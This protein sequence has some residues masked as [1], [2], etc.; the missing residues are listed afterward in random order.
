MSLA[1]IL[2]KKRAA[3][4][5]DVSIIPSP[6]AS[7]PNVTDVIAKP[8]PVVPAPQI[9]A[10]LAAL[11]AKKN[12][13]A[14]E[15]PAQTEIKLQMPVRTSAAPAPS[16]EEEQKTVEDKMAVA[17]TTIAPSLKVQAT[18]I[19]TPLM[20]D[21]SEYPIEIQQQYTDI[22]TRI[23][24]LSSLSTEDLESAMGALK[25]SL[26]ANPAAC[27]LLL[28][29]DIGSMTLALRRS[30]FTAQQDAT[31]DEAAKKTKKPKALDMKNLTPQQIEAAWDDL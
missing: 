4:G 5:G 20:E 7:S 2:A 17:E 1:D 14:V 13:P 3:A 31:T 8:A 21:G 10:G 19:P 23:D 27:E 9:S 22:K 30:M 16:V 28:D 11:L 6:S 12:A 25:K 24:A 15:K 18:S 29:E 26:K